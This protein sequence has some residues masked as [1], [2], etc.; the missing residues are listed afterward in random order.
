MTKPNELLPCQVSDAMKRKTHCKHGHELCAANLYV[1]RTG[2][3]EC[4]ICR[5]AADKR[6]KSKLAGG[7]RKPRNMPFD[8]YVKRAGENDCWEWVGGLNSDGYGLYR[9]HKAHRFAY[10]VA[11]G[12]IPHG[13]FVLHSCDNRRC[14]NPAHLRVGTHTD[15][16]RDM[17]ARGRQP[18]MPVGWSSGENAWN[19]KLNWQTVREIR[20]LTDISDSE[21]ARR[22]GVIPRTIY[23]VRKGKSWVEAGGVS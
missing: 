20:R 6:F 13:L 15:N 23:N 21:F 14:V 22:L 3:R 19:A 16:M 11:H 18:R 2:R 8:Y 12:E 1:S 17:Y 9:N 10:S 7:P 4:R 5:A